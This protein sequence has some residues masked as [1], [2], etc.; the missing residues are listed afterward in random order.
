MSDNKVALGT[1]SDKALEAV[2]RAY[3]TVE[4]R[5]KDLIHVMCIVV[6]KD[7]VGDFHH[8]YYTTNAY[9]SLGVLELSKADMFK[10]M[11]ADSHD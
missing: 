6:Y 10:I 9:E 3:E 7:E 2:L 1:L 8:E 11:Q 5:K 4:E